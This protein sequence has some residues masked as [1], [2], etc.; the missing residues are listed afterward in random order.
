MKSTQSMFACGLL[1]LAAAIGCGGDDDDDGGSKIST[2]LPPGDTLASLS[3]DDTQQVC[4]GTADSLN[5]LLTKSE[6]KLFAC[7]G[8]AVNDILE[9]TEGEAAP[10]KIADCNKAAQA[11]VNDASV[12]VPPLEVAEPGACSSLTTEESFGDCKAT[13]ADYER[14]TGRVASL[15]K[16][17]LLSLNC[18]VLKNPEV[19]NETLNGTVDVT[20]ESACSAVRTKC[21]D[22]DLSFGGAEDDE[23][24]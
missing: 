15:L 5:N 1:A 16:S 6:L 18:D 20:N 2:G 21:P 10:D 13:V 23:E 22:V 8:V 11:C 4:E 9:A 19:I 14:C 7:R 24:G 12:N 3:D 17:R